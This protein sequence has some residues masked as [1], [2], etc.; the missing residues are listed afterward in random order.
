MI[1][2]KEENFSTE[3]TNSGLMANL[4]DASNSTVTI[5]AIMLA[6]IVHPSLLSYGVIQSY[7]FNDYVKITTADAPAFHVSY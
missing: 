7:L 2:P 4:M 3:V 6:A 1:D 5:S